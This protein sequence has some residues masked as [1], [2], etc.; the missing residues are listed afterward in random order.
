[1][2]YQSPGPPFGPDCRPD[3]Q[4][5]AAFGIELSIYRRGPQT[6]RGHDGPVRLPAAVAGVVVAVYCLDNRRLAARETRR[7][8]S[9]D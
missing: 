3:R 6:Y 5:D 8:E 4:I 1:M 9:R 2:T 7:L